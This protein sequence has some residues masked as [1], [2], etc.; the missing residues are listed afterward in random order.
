MRQIAIV[1]SASEDKKRAIIDISLLILLVIT[2]FT[3]NNK[4]KQTHTL[5]TFYVYRRKYAI[6]SKR[7][8]CSVLWV[9]LKRS[10][11]FFY[12]YEAAAILNLYHNRLRFSRFIVKRLFTFYQFFKAE[13][14]WNS[15]FYF[16]FYSSI[17]KSVY[18]E[19]NKRTFLVPVFFS[20]H[21]SVLLFATSKKKY[22]K[23][24]TRLA[25]FFFHCEEKS[26]FHFTYLSIT[27]LLFWACFL[28]NRVHVIQQ[29][30]FRLDSGKFGLDFSIRKSLEKNQTSFHFS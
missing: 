14:S 20:I 3:L 15:A 26:S 23:A 6:L 22:S 7:F 27:T 11:N 21:L 30:K 16:N 19:V 10:A 17:F 12:H 24:E 29:T 25:F 2:N 9:C 13:L 28:G 4:T 5:Y 8:S 18:L 1:Q